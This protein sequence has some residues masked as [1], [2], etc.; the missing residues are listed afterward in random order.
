[1]R[2][3][4]VVVRELTLKLTEPDDLF[5]PRAPHLASGTPSLPSG[6][7]QIRDELDS[8]P[9]RTQV[10]AVILLPRERFKPDLELGM[11]HAVDQ[12]CDAGIRRAD[13]ELRLLRREGLRGLVIGLIVFAVF[14]G[15]SSFVVQSD[16]PQDV[17]TF[18]GE[19][20]FL[21]VA[22]VGLWFPIDTL[23]YSGRPYR[24]EKDVLRAIRG[25]R[26]DV[27]PADY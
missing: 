20:L 15:L 5:V 13:N 16:S 11:R 24:R 23:L 7:D 19:G 27:R 8:H 1:M 2:T 9:P 25:M 18:F 3:R 12:Y 26:I 14:T 17:K 21:V 10:D 22:W 4:N 6:I